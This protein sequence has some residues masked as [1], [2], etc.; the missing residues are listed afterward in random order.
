MN[1]IT[2]AVNK[3]T[4]KNAFKNQTDHHRE[5]RQPLTSPMAQ[6]SGIILYKGPLLGLG[7]KGGKERALEE[8]G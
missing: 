1:C 6:I 8:R 5:K 7:R 2:C 3:E 4:E